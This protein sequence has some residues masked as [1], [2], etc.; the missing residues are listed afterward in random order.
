MHKIVHIK[1]G[2]LKQ[3]F[4]K[5]KTFCLQKLKETFGG[6]EHFHENRGW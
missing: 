2:D 4:F 5:Q 3:I 1:K 6:G